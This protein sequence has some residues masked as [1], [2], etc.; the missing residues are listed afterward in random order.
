MA[1]T[2]PG[3]TSTLIIIIITTSLN[4]LSH[5][6]T[7][8]TLSS[9]A[10][11]AP[12]TPP[13]LKGSQSQSQSQEQ[14]GGKSF[15]QIPTVPL[16]PALLTTYR[17]QSLSCESDL[18]GTGSLDTICSLNQNVS[19]PGEDTLL[20]GS[21][22]LELQ[23]NIFISCCTPGCSLT[24]L[25]Q[26]DLNV[27]SNSSIRASSLWIEAQ[28]VNIGDGASLDCTAFAGKPPSGTS[29]TPNE[30]EGAGAGHGGRGASCLR[31]EG[32]GDQR[33]KWGGDMY[34][35]STL[36]KPWDF[37]S[38]G[39]T[40]E[41]GVELGGEGGGRVNVTVVGILV[42]NGSIEADGGSVGEEGGG[43]SGGSLFVQASRM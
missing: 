29:G 7:C 6:V 31:E 16:T 35:W 40:T 19:F 18:S 34:G 5:T 38:A 24:I 3:F 4:L 17:A 37:G 41:K 27:L 36:M 30:V 20:L 12:W 28:N 1:L 2:H 42:V 32:K 13:K 10:V 9:P 21:G 11:A 15:K 14:E 25:L 43:G 8:T 22:T 23:P 39:G 33:D 26:G